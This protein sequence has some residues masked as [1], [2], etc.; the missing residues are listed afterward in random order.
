MVFFD[1]YWD[2]RLFVDMYWLIK[3]IFGVS[4]LLVGVMD[5]SLISAMYALNI[6]V[7]LLFDDHRKNKKGP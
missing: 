1:Y 3:A 7:N 2:Q 5:T 4:V 6:L